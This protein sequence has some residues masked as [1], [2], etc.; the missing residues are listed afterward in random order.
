MPGAPSNHPILPE[1]GLSECTVGCP[2][3]SAAR[4]F[5]K[6][7]FEHSWDCNCFDMLMN[8]EDFSAEA[9]GVDGV[10][11][12]RAKIADLDS[13]V[14]CALDAEA[15]FA[16]YYRNPA[17]Y[18]SGSPS[19]VMMA[20]ADGMAVGAV[21]VENGDDGTGSVGCTAVRNAWQGRKIATNLVI[22]GTNSLKATGA[23]RSFIGYTYSGL[24]NLYGRAG[25]RICTYYL[26][27]KKALQA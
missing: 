13:V 23:R 20:E 5:A 6:H 17:L 27:A 14:E 4:F 19:H 18:E 8:L 24:D 25:Y 2:D 26:M 21:I 11:F 3:D 1:D 15:G 12:R 10:T 16:K 9:G 22:H 7:G